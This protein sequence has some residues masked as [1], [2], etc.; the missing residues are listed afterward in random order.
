MTESAAQRR[1]T[2]QAVKS[3]DTTPEMRVRRLLHSMGYR[4]RLHRDCLPGTPDL[5][6]VSRRKV[7]FVH[8]C[9]WHGHSCAR[10]ARV[11]K[12]N[13]EYWLKKVA[14][15]RERDRVVRSDLETLGWDA[16][17]VWECETQDIDKLR[18]KVLEFL[19]A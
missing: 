1:R 6:F 14:R 9:F 7:I 8:G 19:E 15:N 18:A 11:P 17:V 4:Y 3:K 5:V 2:M 16:L 10:G 13:R 12:T